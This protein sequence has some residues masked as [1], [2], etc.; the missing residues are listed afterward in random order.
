MRIFRLLTA[1]ITCALL[2]AVVVVMSNPKLVADL[3][4]A[5]L[6]YSTPE[7]ARASAEPTVSEG[8]P[9]PDPGALPAG[10]VIS[11]GRLVTYLGYSVTVGAEITGT[12]TEMNVVENQTIKKGDVIARMRNDDLQA[13]LDL[14]QAD[15][16]EVNAEIEYWTKEV[17]RL[18]SLTRRSAAPQA[19]LDLGIR[20]LAV[21][22]ARQVR[23]RAAIAQAAAILDKTRIVAPIDGTVVT[24]SAHKGE[25]LTVG[26]P[27]VELIDLTRVRIETEVDEYDVGKIALGADCVITAEGFPGHRWKGTVEEIPA[28]VVA[29]RI[30]PEDPSRPADTRVVVA[31]VAF[32]E[33]VPLK[34]GQ[35]VYVSFVPLDSSAPASAPLT[36]GPN[37]APA[38]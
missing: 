28:D 11:E 16:V 4:Q 2:A 19:D 23:A 36:I 1:A 32:R 10:S 25:T 27:I 21:M 30:R 31:K 34:L 15:L 8:R 9:K 33:P 17:A 24:R 14:A 12:L 6:K 13:S 26:S 22:K 18:S 7:A 38:P 29:R 35:R 20:S 37:S 3:R 5:R